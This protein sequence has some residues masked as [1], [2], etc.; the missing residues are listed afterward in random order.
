[1]GNLNVN[2]TTTIID[3]LINNTS[4][5]S[6]SVSGPSIYYSNVTLISSLN[7]SGSTR[8]NSATTLISTL[9]V[10]G[11]TT[12]N[13]NTTLLSS[14]NISGRTIIGSNIYDYSDSLLE[15]Y[16]N[17]SIRNNITNGSRI[18]LKVGAG[19]NSSY[20]SMEEG[21]DINLVTPLFSTSQSIIRLASNKNINLETPEV[22]ISNN[23]NIN[24]NITGINIGVKTPLFFT[25]NRNVSINGTTFSVYDIDLTKYTK[26]ILLDGYNIRQFRIR[27]WPADGHFEYSSTN[28]NELYLKRYDIF[29]SDKNG[30]SIFSMSSPLENYYLRDTF[31]SQFLYR[32]SFNNLIFCSRGVAVKV[33]FIIEDLL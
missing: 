5:N 32:N 31:G 7:V 18:D 2:G 14:L 6:L 16:K 4:M 33:Y 26:Y 24:G 29:M 8:L 28:F 11:S 19:Y 17:L 23:L 12:L 3:T 20:L 10:S 22:Y 30:L 27:H 25:T 21:Y 13:N 15:V 9:K 1:M